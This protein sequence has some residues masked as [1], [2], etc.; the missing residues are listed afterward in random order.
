MPPG[1]IPLKVGAAVSNVATMLNVYDALRDKPVTHRYLTV[2][3]EVAKPQVLRVPIGTSFAECLA[4][5]GGPTISDYLLINGGPMMG[6]VSPGAE[7]GSFYVTKTCSGMLVVGAEG[8]FVARTQKLTV[9]QILNRAKSACI[10]CSYCSDLCPRRL[11]GHQIRPHRIMRKMAMHDLSSP[12]IP[13]DIYRES[14]FCSQCGVCETFACPMGLSPRQVNKYVKDM[15]KGEKFAQTE[16]LVA[17]PLRPYRKIAPRKIMARMGL[18]EL[19]NNKPETFLDL[20]VQKVHIPCSQHIGAPAEAV[21]SKGDTVNVG[22]LIAKA[23]EG[24]PSANIHASIAGRVVS[25][26]SVIE[27]EGG[28]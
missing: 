26:G 28:K 24:K 10:Q 4:A 2:A 15:L 22:Q 8:S 1:G 11:I 23:A 9:E 21:V 14:L 27:I 12:I 13:D 3:G 17:S 16:K 20:A 7:A 5:C 19:Y 18:S 6:R 25:V